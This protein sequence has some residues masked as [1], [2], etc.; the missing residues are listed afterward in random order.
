M[1]EIIDKVFK[2]REFIGICVV[3]HNENVIYIY[4]KVNGNILCLEYKDYDYDK[5][6]LPVKSWFK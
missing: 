6:N 5:L 1:V 3:K 4:V 2:N